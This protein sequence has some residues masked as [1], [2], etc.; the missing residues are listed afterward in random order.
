MLPACPQPCLP[1][2]NSPAF[3][4][5]YLELSYKCPQGSEFPSLAYD[6]QPAGHHREHGDVLFLFPGLH[7]AHQSEQDTGLGSLPTCCLQLGEGR[8][9]RPGP[10]ISCPTCAAPTT[11]CPRSPCCRPHRLPW[12]LPQ[13]SASS[14][15]SPFPWGAFPAFLH[16]WLVVTSPMIPP[17]LSLHSS[18]FL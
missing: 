18:I 15:Q 1:P 3:H 4:L 12:P 14:L 10:H 13:T 5:F 6:P 7:T 2:S 8:W 17:V 9:F 11:I 16:A